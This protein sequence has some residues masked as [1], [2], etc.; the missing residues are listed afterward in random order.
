MR[1]DDYLR[2][3]G[4]FEDCLELTLKESKVRTEI[5]ALNN[6]GN[7]YLD[8]KKYLNALMYFQQALRKSEGIHDMDAVCTI[9]NNIGN[10]K[11]HLAEI[12]AAKKFFTRAIDLG[13][14]LSR[15][16]ILWEA[17]FGLGRCYELKEE[18]SDAI[19]Y[20]KMAVS[21]IDR[22]RSQITM[23]T[24]KS[25]FARNKQKVYESQIRLLFRL[26]KSENSKDLGE[27][28]HVVEGAK[29]R[30]KSRR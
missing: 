12:D 16:E 18:Y 8:L 4:Y 10:A 5:K 6:I 3:L 13:K 21:V 1:G 2:A 14:K 30:E 7:I 26:Q 25:S 28:F 29:A 17:Y 20:Y 27:I 15:G 19:F 23:D 24:Y 11:F 22:I 9:L